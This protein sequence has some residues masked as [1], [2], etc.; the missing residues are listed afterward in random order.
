MHGRLPRLN[1]WRMRSYVLNRLWVHGTR[2]THLIRNMP[3]RDPARRAAWMR[4]YRRRKRTA[5]ISAPVSSISIVP[6]PEPSLVPQRI[7]ERPSPPP[8]RPNTEFVRKGSS[9]S[10]KTALELAPTFP[11]GMLAS[12]VCPYCYNTGYSSLG[13]RCSYCRRG[14]R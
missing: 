8:A 2:C 4:E 6:A 5:R 13:T 7:I 3:Y 10:F 14:E 11:V 1:Q 9:S 12:Q